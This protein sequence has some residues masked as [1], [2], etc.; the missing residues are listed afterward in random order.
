MRH[1]LIAMSPST[2]VN[3]METAFF[4][5]SQ[6]C[7]R[8]TFSYSTSKLIHLLLFPSHH[9]SFLSYSFP[10]DVFFYLRPSLSSP[11]PVVYPLCSR[12]YFFLLLL[13]WWLLSLLSTRCLLPALSLG[14]C[15]SSHLALTLLTPSNAVRLN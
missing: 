15:S 10:C 1:V 5:L 12:C 8:A 9:S 11:L 3:P 2:M 13:S 14:W 4:S 6:H 7:W